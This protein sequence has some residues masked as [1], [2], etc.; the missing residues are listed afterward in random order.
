MHA[1][2]AIELH[3]AGDGS[4]VAHGALALAPYWC[5]WDGATLWIVGSA[6]TPVGEDDITLDLRVGEGVRAT[7]RSV[8]AMVVYAGRGA[9]TRLTTRLHVA[10]GASLRW[11]PEPVI[12]TA[13]A[14]HR[15]VLIADVASGGELVAD[16]VVVLGRS[17]EVAGAY[18][19]A[20]D[21]R[22][23]GVPICLTSFDTAAPGWSG[24]AGTAGAKVVGTRLVIDATTAIGA[25]TPRV[26]A[27][28]VVLR[29]EGGGTIA[30]TLAPDPGRARAQLD[31]ALAGPAAGAD[32][33][34]GL[35]SVGSGPPA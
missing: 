3:R 28:T 23:D 6:A 20:T 19:S 12:V 15:S 5:R 4:V 34:E 13:R 1:E 11:Q 9:G 2:L 21:L 31:A 26:D 7:V 22:R 16:E 33:D 24:P 35:A 30:T 17:D 27:S 8:A 18:V 29:P 14:R 32:R 25:P 10:A